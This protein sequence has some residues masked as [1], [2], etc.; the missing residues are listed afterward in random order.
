MY[1]SQHELHGQ[2]GQC[3]TVQ[4][5]CYLP[6]PGVDLGRCHKLDSSEISL[7]GLFHCSLKYKMLAKLHKTTDL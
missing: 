2:V 1:I 5:S 6:R 3:G 4:R 7:T